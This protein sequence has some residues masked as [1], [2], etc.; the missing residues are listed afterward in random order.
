MFVIGVDAFRPISLYAESVVI[1]TIN[2]DFNGQFIICGDMFIILKDVVT[3]F[4]IE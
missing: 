1:T 2:I 3:S 4:S